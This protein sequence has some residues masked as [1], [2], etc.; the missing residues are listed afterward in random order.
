MSTKKLLKGGVAVP[1]P[2]FPPKE[3]DKK[4][5]VRVVQPTPAYVVEGRLRGQH[6]H[7]LI[8]SGADISLLTN[9]LAKRCNIAWQPFTPKIG[10]AN[11]GSVKVIGQ[12]EVPLQKADEAFVCYH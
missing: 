12:A 10:A 1:T 4:L 11:G 7:F 6:V 8:D 5:E 2:P 3:P 9:A